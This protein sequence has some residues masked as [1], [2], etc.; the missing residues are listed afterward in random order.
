M[1]FIPM[2]GRRLSLRGAKHE[3]RA[4][5]EKYGRGARTVNFAGGSS[6]ARPCRI[7]GKDLEVVRNGC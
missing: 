1:P 5:E 2:T 3:K 6:R 4:V 7:K